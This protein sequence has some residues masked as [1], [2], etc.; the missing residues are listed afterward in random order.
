MFAAYFSWGGLTLHIRVFADSSRA[1]HCRGCAAAMTWWT[2]T[3][4]QAIPLNLDAR[5]LEREWSEDH[6][7]WV[8]YYHRRD[9]HQVTC[10]ERWQFARPR[11]RAHSTATQIELFAE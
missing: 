5:L 6:S 4:G 11:R 1:G 3:T 10:P 9:V 8:N 2:T 7:R